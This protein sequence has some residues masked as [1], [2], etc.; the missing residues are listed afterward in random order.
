[1]ADKLFAKSGKDF[2]VAFLTWLDDRLTGRKPRSSEVNS[3]WLQPLGLGRVLDAS[4]TRY[5]APVVTSSL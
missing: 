4:G 1:M 3:K 5:V 2:T